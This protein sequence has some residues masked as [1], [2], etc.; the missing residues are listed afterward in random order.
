[1][2]YVGTDLPNNDPY[3]ATQMRIDFVGALNPGEAPA[4]VTSL[5]LSVVAN[6]VP[7]PAAGTRIV[8]GSVAFDD[9]GAYAT[10]AAGCVAGARYQLRAI[11]GTNQG[12]TYDL[13]SFFNCAPDP[14]V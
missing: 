3:T 7:D 6:W 11:I 14:G 9:T 2:P 4:S 1:M 10:V 8:P 13:W 5:K 12:N